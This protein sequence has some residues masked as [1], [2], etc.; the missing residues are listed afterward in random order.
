MEPVHVNIRIRRWLRKM[1][2]NGDEGS[3]TVTGVALIAVCAVMLTM[4]ASVGN[5]V[6]TQSR[7]RTVADLTALSGATALWLAQG[8]ACSVAGAVAQEQGGQ[9]L[10]CDSEQE[11]IIVEISMPTRIPFADE[12]SS[13]ARA[14]P[15]QCR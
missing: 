3:G 10:R 15:D 11:D 8:D 7:V 5:F 4:L 6:I 13:T 1:R 2:L 14:G 9:V 12:V